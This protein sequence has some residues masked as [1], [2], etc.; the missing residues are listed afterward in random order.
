MGIENW[1]KIGL[2]ESWKKLRAVIRQSGTRRYKREKGVGPNRKSVAK[3]RV[4]VRQR[5]AARSKLFR[6]NVN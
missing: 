5:N 2:K 3:K 4:D 1:L 6:D